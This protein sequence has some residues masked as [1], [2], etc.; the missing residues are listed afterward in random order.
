MGHSLTEMITLSDGKEEQ[1]V[2]AVDQERVRVVE[3]LMRQHRAKGSCHLW[4]KIPYEDGHGVQ[5]VGKNGPGVDI[6]S[7]WIR[8]QLDFRPDFLYG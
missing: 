3:D 4:D 7:G 8:V 5:G 1:T 2:A 6:D